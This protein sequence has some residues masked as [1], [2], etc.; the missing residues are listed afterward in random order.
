MDYGP[1]TT[2]LVPWRIFDHVSAV[3]PCNFRRRIGC[4][5]TLE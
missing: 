2:N 4:D 3:K 1:K 5:A